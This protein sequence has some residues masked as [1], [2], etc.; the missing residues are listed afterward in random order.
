MSLRSDDYLAEKRD[1]TLAQMKTG[2]LRW[3]LGS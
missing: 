1:I 2:V 3:K